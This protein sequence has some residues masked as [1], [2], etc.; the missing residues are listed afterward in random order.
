[1]RVNQ[2]VAGYLILCELANDAETVVY[3]ARDLRF[4]HLVALKVSRSAD[5]VARERLLR[6]ARYMAA[7][8]QAAPYAGI[9]GL[10]AV[11]EYH[12]DAFIVME[13]VEG[14]KLADRL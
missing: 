8:Q 2:E 1:W 3:K 11:D 4:N 6:A 10:Y 9:V 12:G 5:A 13:L 7:V 14:G